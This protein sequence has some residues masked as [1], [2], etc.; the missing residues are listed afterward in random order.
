MKMF[1]VDS[2]LATSE[3]VNSKLV[4]IPF[5][6]GMLKL[7]AGIDAG[8]CIKTAELVKL[9]DDSYRIVREGRDRDRRAMIY[10]ACPGGCQLRL[11]ANT[12]LEVVEG[13]AVVRVP[14]PF[15]GAV[16]C[17]VIH[18]DEQ[19]AIVTLIPR[20]SFRLAYEGR[21]PQGV[22]PQAVILWSGRYDANRPT[23]G[24]SAFA[25]NNRL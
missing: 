13:G 24:L 14:R 5:G 8:V 21:R 10:V 15:E 2:T 12:V 4:R 7:L 11:F 9:K 23:A 25:R 18:Q 22:P 16:G 17:G 6:D 3:G 1:T 20:A 19:G